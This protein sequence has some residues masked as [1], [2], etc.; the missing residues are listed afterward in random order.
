MATFGLAR[1]KRPLARLAERI[2]YDLC[3]VVLRER[4][5]GRRLPLPVKIAL[6]R[7]GFLTESHAVYDLARNDPRDYLPDFARHFRGRNIN[8][9]Y[10]PVLSNKL[11]F[12][13]MLRAHWPERLPQVHGLLV[14]D[15]EL[16]LSESGERV[17]LLH[18]FDEL[19]P[20]ARVVLKP[21]DRSVGIGF[22]LLERS[23]G[24]YRLNGQEAVADDL[25]RELDELRNY[26]VS[27]CIEA[28]AYSRELFPDAVNSIRL[29]T[30]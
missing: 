29:L 7:Q 2:N 26:L 30:I 16:L 6:W 19:G 22:R 13:W 21:L 23:G 1:L 12:D 28:H 24:G 4:H 10:T 3:Q 17:K 11:V 15:G 25:C 5:A 8:G 27:E 14:R 9:V 20:G 18:W